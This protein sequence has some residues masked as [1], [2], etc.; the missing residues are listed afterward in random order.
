MT[1]WVRVMAELW[2][3]LG[4]GGGE[5]QAICRDTGYFL[6]INCLTVTIYL[7]QQPWLRYVLYRVSF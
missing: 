4:A 2:L 6:T 5:G 7:G 1:G 3:W